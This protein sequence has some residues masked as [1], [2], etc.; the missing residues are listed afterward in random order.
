MYS[1]VLLAALSA[2][3]GSVG[4]G[5]RGYPVSHCPNCGC[6]YGAGYGGPN[7]GDFWPGY[8]GWGGCGGYASPA[9]GIPMTP[10][11]T[12]LP[13]RAIDP[14]DRRLDDGKKKKAADDDADADKPRK[15]RPKKPDDE[16]E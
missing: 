16:D 8:S 4:A 10:L 3:D 12:P 13:K 1:V 7:A 14:D 5:L 2:A 6:G 9:Y 15:R 11:V